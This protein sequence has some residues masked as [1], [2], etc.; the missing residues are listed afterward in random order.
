MYGLGIQVMKTLFSETAFWLVYSEQKV[1]KYHC[2]H[3]CKLWLEF[4]VII[5]QY[6]STVSVIKF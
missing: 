6:I 4:I 1:G 3:I 5:M 2:T